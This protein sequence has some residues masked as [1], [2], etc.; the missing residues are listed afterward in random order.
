MHDTG[1]VNIFQ[2]AVVFFL[3]KKNGK[4]LSFVVFTQI[5]VVRIFQVFK[6]FLGSRNH[7]STWLGV[8]LTRANK[9]LSYCKDASF[10]F[11]FPLQ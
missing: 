3:S 10:L 4:H 5:R 8:S 6:T 1:S 2:I 11:Q 7:T 9:L